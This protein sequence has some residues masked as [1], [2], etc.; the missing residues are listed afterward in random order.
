MELSKDLQPKLLRALEKREIKR[1]GAR[2]TTTVDAFASSRR[3]TATCWPR[4]S[5]GQ[6]RQDLYY[7]D[8]RW[9][10][11]RVP[12]LRDRL[13]DLRALVEHF[14]ALERT[15]MTAAEVPPEVW[16]MF[17]AHRWPGNVREL[18]NAVQRLL[19]TPRVTLDGTRARSPGVIETHAGA[20]S[21]SCSRPLRIA[22]RRVR[23]T[24]SSAP[25]LRTLLA[26]TEGNVTRGGG[27]RRGVA[28]R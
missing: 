1:I 21:R 24:P 23:P 4:S 14:L 16:D 7:S 19:V 22:R 2:K 9:R 28:G 8:R 20:E 13:D 5:E 25:T 3:R 12:P 26:K 15:R 27:H 10:T 11:L 18:R 6:F 17:R